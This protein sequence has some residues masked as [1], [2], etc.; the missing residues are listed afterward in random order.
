MGL[1]AK[2]STAVA[3]PIIPAKPASVA[4]AARP[5]AELPARPA[6]IAPTSTPQQVER[7]AYLQ[8]MKVRIHQQLVNRLDLQNL[9]TLP[10]ETVR[11]E[12]RVLVRELC[13]SEKG[14]ISRDRKSVV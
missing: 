14:L 4:P 8:Q 13:Q 6:I 9:R 11:E 2:T 12:V 3:E 7:Q 10:P 1:F 5:G